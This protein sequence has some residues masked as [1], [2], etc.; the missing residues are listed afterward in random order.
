[1]GGETGNFVAHAFG[2]C[3]GDLI[4]YA[5]V[6]VEVKRETSIVL[7][8]DG[9]CALFDGFGTNSLLSFVEVQKGGRKMKS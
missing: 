3:D 5:L 8:N 4:D 7:L 2:G 9:A 6:S 1:M